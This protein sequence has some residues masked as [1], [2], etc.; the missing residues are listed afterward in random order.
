MD[1]IPKITINCFEETYIEN[2]CDTLRISREEFQMKLNSTDTFS[3]NSK[4]EQYIKTY[5]FNNT[6]K[7]TEDNWLIAKELYIQWK[8]FEGIEQEDVSKDKKESLHEIL[9]LYKVSVE[10]DEEKNN[11][12][13]C[14]MMIF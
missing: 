1:I 14:G 8:I 13:F 6:K 11:Q 2:V 4:A 9:D 3:F 5:L 12:V 7:L 10:K